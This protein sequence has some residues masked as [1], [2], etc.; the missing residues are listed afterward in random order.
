MLGCW[1]MLYP[2]CH[3]STEG[4]KLWGCPSPE[5]APLVAAP[6][7]TVLTLHAWQAA[8]DMLATGREAP[9]NAKHVRS[10]HTIQ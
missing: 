4:C 3:A 10:C 5:P 7:V 2:A 1:G 9:L 8:E 6:R